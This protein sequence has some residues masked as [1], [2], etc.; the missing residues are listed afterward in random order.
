[1]SRTTSE[2]GIE[3][4]K[5]FEGCRLKAYLCPANK[6]TIG[7]G[8]TSNVTSNMTITQAQAESYLKED[9]AKFEANVNKYHDRYTWNQNEFDAL[10][11][12]AY[13]IGSIDQLIANGTRSRSVIAQKMILYVNKGT[14][15]E[16]GLTVRREAERGL[17]LSST[18]D[19]ETELPENHVL[20]ADQKAYNIKT[21]QKW[22]N[23]IYGDD[24]KSCKSCGNKLLNEDGKNGNKTRAALTIALQLHLNE[25]GASLKI[26]GLYGTGT[27]NAVKTYI[28]YVGLG[29]S[30][31]ASKIVQAVL[32]AYGYNPQMF[33]N[34][35]TEEC[36]TALKQCQED[37]NLN[38]DGKAGVIFFTTFLKQR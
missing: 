38:A 17:F 20:T 37:K 26:D 25:L 1:M 14:S 3:L 18:C 31:I 16:K 30:T 21:V 12:F 29:N 23:D 36:A 35:F 7:Y 33:Y 34:D 27:N 15:F 5:R 8:H 11:S 32:Y 13:N 4:I 22:L 9:L 2:T 6:L 24:I 28:K 19:T 10:V